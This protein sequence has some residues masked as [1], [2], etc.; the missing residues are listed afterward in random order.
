[1]KIFAFIFEHPSYIT[2]FYRSKNTYNR[3]KN[4]IVIITEM[5]YDSNKISVAMV[6]YRTIESITIGALQ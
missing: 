3:N 1:M 2:M 6:C 5:V 4:Y